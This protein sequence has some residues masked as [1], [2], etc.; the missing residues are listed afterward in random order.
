MPQK[1]LSKNFITILI[2]AAYLVLHIF[3]MLYFAP[4]NDEVI[5]AHLAR[6]MSEDWQKNKFLSLHAMGE[7]YFEPLQFWV[8]AL[9]V[10]WWK[11]PLLGVRIWSLFTGLLGLIYTQRLVS[12]V[13]NHAAAVFT[14]VF[15]VSSEYFFYFGSLGL[16]EVHLYGLGA[17]FLYYLYQSLTRKSWRN[18]IIAT[19][20]LA[21]MLTIKISGQFW[22]GFAVII[23]VLVVTVESSSLN[24]IVNAIKKMGLRMYVTVFSIL[25]IAFGIHRIVIPIEY[26]IYK[27]NSQQ[28][29]YVRSVH[30]LMEIPFMEWGSNLNFYINQVFQREFSFLAV[31]LLIFIGAV[32]IWLWR[33]QKNLLWRFLCLVILYFASFV[34]LILVAKTTA[35]RHFGI[36][37]YFFYILIGVAAAVAFEKQNGNFKKISISILIALLIGW[38]GSTSYADLFRWEQT[39]MAAHETLGWANGAGMRELI[40]MISNLPAGTVI[41]DERRGHPGTTIHLYNRFFPQLNL[42]D[43][44]QQVFNNL[45]KYYDIEQK[46]G[47]QLY[48]VFDKTKLGGRNWADYLF[49]HQQYCATKHVVPKIFRDQEMKN[50]S[51]V[52]CQAG[53]SPDSSDEQYY[54]IAVEKL[55]ESINQNPKLMHSYFQRGK[56]FVAL[57]QHQNAIEDLS[58]VIQEESVP[59]AFLTRGNA[60]LGLGLYE[61]AVSDLSMEIKFDAENPVVYNNRG[62]AYKMLEQYDKAIDDFSRAI[63]IDPK[64][65]RSYHHRGLVFMETGKPELACSDWYKACQLGFCDDLQNAKEKSIC[66][67]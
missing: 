15:I 57:K 23:P 44:N 26:D 7:D 16:N 33:N 30:E 38:K 17:V 42:V 25:L 58:K 52:I 18:R 9:T 47:R 5:Y 22:V 3:G 32:V 24:E 34:P 39:E 21:A 51:I 63:K 19:L 29:S 50:T 54:R 28:A 41:T 40:F 67:R 13:W 56:L 8:T 64:F 43:L 1:F 12:C 10:N 48:F 4:H 59:G 36:G 31:P 61:K 20:V 37:L 60:Y 62:F 2:A 65:Q 6:I 49:T 14:G 45:E 53:N 46:R 27:V 11:D 35:I 55:T 66:T